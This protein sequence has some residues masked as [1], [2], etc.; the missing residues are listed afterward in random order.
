MIVG[1]GIDIIEIKRIAKIVEKRV[2]FLQR[3]FTIEERQ[4]FDSKEKNKI[5]SI[6]GYY[7]AKEAAAKA[8]GTG[9]S[10]FKWQDIEIKKTP[11]G[12]PQIELR[13]QAKIQAQSRGIE[14]MVLSISH[15]KEYAVAQAIAWGEPEEKKQ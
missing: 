4:Y 7:A 8:L 10:G 3:F 13:G 14:K 1:T 11:Q 15:C 12:Q 6:A 9:L 5:E 2:T